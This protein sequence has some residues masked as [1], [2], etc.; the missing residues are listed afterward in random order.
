MH[1]QVEARYMALARQVMHFEKGRFQEWA[2]HAEEAARTQL[3]RPLLLED[4]TNGRC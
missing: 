3:R 4:V 2:A 1:A